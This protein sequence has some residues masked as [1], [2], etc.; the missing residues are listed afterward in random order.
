VLFKGQIQALLRKYQVNLS[1]E[2]DWK[3]LV[4]DIEE[5]RTV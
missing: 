3:A 4:V 5:S 1:D 2:I